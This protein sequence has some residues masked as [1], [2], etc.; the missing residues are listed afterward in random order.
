M[1]K[2]TTTWNAN[3]VGADLVSV[4]LLGFDPISI[5]QH[6]YNLNSLKK[7]PLS[8]NIPLAS[9]LTPSSFSSFSL[10]ST[11]CPLGTV[12]QSPLKPPMYWVN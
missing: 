3:L 2:A 7:W 5:S 9:N 8:T 11:F 6:S 10:L 1:V 12:R 4:P